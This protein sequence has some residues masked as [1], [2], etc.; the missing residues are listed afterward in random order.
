MRRN[1]DVS[2]SAIN[3]PST[4]K[5]GDDRRPLQDA[6]V[7]DNFGNNVNDGPQA[8]DFFKR[9]LPQN[10][11][12]PQTSLDPNHRI[13]QPQPSIGGWVNQ[14]IEKERQK[15]AN[16]K[17]GAATNA[18][19][20]VAPN[21]ALQ[22]IVEDQDVANLNDVSEDWVQ[23]GEGLDANKVMHH[24]FIIIKASVT[25]AITA[26][27]KARNNKSFNPKHNYERL[28]KAI[29]VM[30]DYG[31]AV[32][33][34]ASINEKA[35]VKLDLSGQVQ[36]TNDALAEFQ[37][38]ITRQQEREKAIISRLNGNAA[39]NFHL[40]VTTST[41]PSPTPSNQSP[42]QERNV[43]SNVTIY[44]NLRHD[45]TQNQVGPTQAQPISD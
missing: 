44:T 16:R 34:A 37:M 28:E 32:I 1:S 6:Q 19:T 27:R 12:P 10:E 22:A 29:K 41:R 14:I 33:A 8:S 7:T 18:I 15:V 39:A 2:H 43:T 9:P 25:K 45:V 13:F 20:P 31:G 30:L 21:I 24:A 35:K 23:G 40:G 42:T 3:R 17:P 38:D 4:L 11:P 5:L 26:A 36:V